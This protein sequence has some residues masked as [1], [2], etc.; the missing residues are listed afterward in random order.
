MSAAAGEPVNVRILD[1]DY[2]IACPPEEREDLM[3]AA[4]LLDARLKTARES[5]RGMGSERWLIMA[6]LN[7]ANDLAKLRYL[8]LNLCRQSN[9][10]PCML[11]LERRRFRDVSLTNIDNHHDWLEREET[12]TRGDVPL[13]LIGDGA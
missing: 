13:L 9:G 7:M 5:A 10:R 2:L 3:R 12:E 4:T 1:K 6:A 11:V 8:R